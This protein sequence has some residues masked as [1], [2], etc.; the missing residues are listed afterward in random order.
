MAARGGF[1][2]DQALGNQRAGAFFRIMYTTGKFKQNDSTMEEDCR[3]WASTYVDRAIELYVRWG[4]I[5]V[6]KAISKEHEA[7]PG[8]NLSTRIQT[9]DKKEKDGV[10]A[11]SRLGQLRVS[12]KAVDASL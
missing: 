12:S 8:L 1:T 6:S 4:A 2:Q 7:L 11:R 10:K 3:F 5:E 9:T